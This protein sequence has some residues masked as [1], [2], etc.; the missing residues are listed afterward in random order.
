MIIPVLQMR[1]LHLREVNREKLE[2]NGVSSFL[3]SQL[4]LDE[5]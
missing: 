4:L 5:I 2:E 1:K 3:T